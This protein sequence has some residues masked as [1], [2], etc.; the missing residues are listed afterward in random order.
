MA[1]DLFTT[2]LRDVAL[3]IGF[4]IACGLLGLYDRKNHQWERADLMGGEDW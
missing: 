1:L 3:S 2:T 4:G